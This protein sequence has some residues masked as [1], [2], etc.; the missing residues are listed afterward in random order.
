MFLHPD[1]RLDLSQYGRFYAVRGKEMDMGR[2]TIK[3][4]SSLLQVATTCNILLIA[5]VLENLFQTKLRK[6]AL[7]FQWS[8]LYCHRHTLMKGSHQQY[9]GSK[10]MK[11]RKNIHQNEN[12]NRE[13]LTGCKNDAGNE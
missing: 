1:S 6:Q 8:E 13:L 4:L 12:T 10:K 2:S 5:Y 9:D 3:V 11:I 7:Q